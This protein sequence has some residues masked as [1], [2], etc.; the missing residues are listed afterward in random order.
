M[1]TN[2]DAYRIFLAVAQNGSFSAAANKLFISQP[3][4]SQSIKNLEADLGCELFVRSAK[5]VSLTSHGKVLFDHVHSALG[6]IAAGEDKIN[7]LNSLQMGQLKIGASDT[8]TRYYLLEFIDIFHNLYPK[9]D[10]KMTNR[11][12]TE[13]IDFL[14]DG[15][16]ELA[17][18]N[19]PLHDP[20]ITIIE[21]GT[22]EDIFV[23]GAKFWRLKERQLPLEELQSYPLIMLEQK[24]NSRRYVDNFFAR[25]GI[26]LKPEFDLGAHE[27]L[28]EFARIGLGVACV[29]REFSQDYLA[30]GELFEV[31]LQSPIPRR[32]I[33]ICHRK[34]IALSKGATQ[35]IDIVLQAE[36]DRQSRRREGS[37]L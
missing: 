28:L 20:D 12:S 27:L 31:H 7:R 25:R 23:A 16:V 37:Y 10:L 18:V 3:A 34:D 33:G 30:S 36:K 5:G 29:I 2:L 11:T 8:L 15:L 14:K 13:I 6:L 4:V 19:L 24:S 21:C 32:K 17:F 1:K 9:V 26:T 35:F 22:V